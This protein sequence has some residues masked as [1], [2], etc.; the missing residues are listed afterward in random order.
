MSATKLMNAVIKTKPLSPIT[1]KNPILPMATTKPIPYCFTWRVGCFYYRYRRIYNQECHILTP[2]QTQTS[3]KCLQDIFKRSW[4]PTTKQDIVT[5]SRKRHRIYDVLKTSYL[6]CLEDVEF[7]T[8]WRRLIYVVLKTSN[9][10]RL[11][12]IWFT[13]SSG[14]LI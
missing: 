12:N 8:S 4:R 1:T 9:L 2:Q 3:L 5:T 10:G 11:E 13:T 7:T 14:R 6:R